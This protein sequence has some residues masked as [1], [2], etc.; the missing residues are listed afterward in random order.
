MSTAPITR[1]LSKK[2]PRYTETRNPYRMVTAGF[3]VSKGGNLVFVNWGDPSFDDRQQAL[4]EMAAHLTELGFAVG[5]QPQFY[6]GKPNKF[7]DY[8]VVEVQA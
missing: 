2:F 1:A 4:T 6:M 8:L 7:I 3:E 5:I